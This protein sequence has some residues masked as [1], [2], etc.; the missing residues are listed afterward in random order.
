MYLSKELSSFVQKI[1]NAKM[2]PKS[3][4]HVGGDNRTP[5]WRDDYVDALTIHS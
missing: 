2:A 4:K 5:L 3:L 1:Q